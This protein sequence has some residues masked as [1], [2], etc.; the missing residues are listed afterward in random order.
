[1]IIKDNKKLKKV[2]FKNERELQTFF[3]ENL[4]EIL[5]IDLVSSEFTVDKYR[6]DSVAYDSEK[7]AFRIIEYKNVKNRI[8]VDQSYAYLNLLHTRKA[9]FILN[10]NEVN[11]INLRIS[12]VD[13]SQS[14]II[15]ISTR[16]SN[17]Q[18]D[19]TSFKYMPFDLSEIEKYEN[20]I[21]SVEDK[22]K[23]TNI[24]V[25]DF[26]SDVDQETLKEIIIYDE[27]YHLSNKPEYI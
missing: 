20:N 4:N 5:R 6:I 18:I 17:Y 19:A 1:M 24:T 7:K 22:S 14:R 11:G 21:I 13:W 3:E 15:F 23:R 16:F 12:D 2:D 27:T 8:L 10:Y 25:E 9:D 26:V